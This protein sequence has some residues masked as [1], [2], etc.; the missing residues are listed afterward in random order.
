M[1]SLLVTDAGPPVGVFGKLPALGD[2][3][4]RDLEPAFTGRWFEWLEG[5]LLA[6]R[7]A[8]G[9]RFQAA[10]M[11]APA[12]R[13]ALP[14]GIAGG[15]P[16]TGVL[17]PS[18]DSIGRGFPLTLAA[19]GPPEGQTATEGRP[20]PRRAGRRPGRRGRGKHSAAQREGSRRD[21][22]ATGG[23]GRSGT[24]EGVE[25]RRGEPHARGAGDSREGE[26]TLQKAPQVTR[27]SD[28]GG[29]MPLFEYRC[30]SCDRPFE[31]LVTS[32][33]VDSVRCPECQSSEVDRL[34]GL[35]AAGKVADAAPA[36]NCRRPCSGSRC[37]GCSWPAPQGRP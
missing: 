7:A 1:P 22:R 28:D 36:T 29:S 24:R 12:W 15:Q 30:R 4:A 34:L 5:G 17:V 9:D 6:A 18:V 20:A 32:R 11:E 14:A 19:V 31:V 16:V 21:R 8:L 2:F 13:F 26:R 27:R 23:A 35:P 10:Y 33:T 37:S 25:V 3:L